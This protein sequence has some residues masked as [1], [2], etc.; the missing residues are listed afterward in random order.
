MS[1]P[2]FLGVAPAP[3][4]EA[5]ETPAELQLE[6]WVQAIAL[7]DLRAGV[8]AACVCAEQA[9][10]VARQLSVASG[11]DFGAPDQSWGGALA[12]VE[13]VARVRRWLDEGLPIPPRT[14]DYSRQQNIWD[15]DMRP[16]A[17][18][19]GDWFTYFVEASNLLVMAVLHGDDPGPYGEWPG[20]P[21]AARSALCSYKAMNGPGRD[22]DADLASLR[23]A[24]QAA[25]SP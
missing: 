11:L 16:V 20:V 14:A 21:C 19:P 18:Y 17:A 15:D 10:E 7:V 9:C 8:L 2:A 23:A 25:L 3:S 22:R 13:Q 1:T 24:V 6:G 5:G 12:P 4:W